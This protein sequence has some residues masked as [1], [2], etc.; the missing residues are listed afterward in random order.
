M[1]PTTLHSTLA[2]PL[3]LRSQGSHGVSGSRGGTIKMP[4]APV[5]KGRVSDYFSETSDNDDSNEEE[6]RG[7]AMSDSDLGKAHGP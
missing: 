3:L 6:L 2:P 5:G 7:L 1:D 4:V